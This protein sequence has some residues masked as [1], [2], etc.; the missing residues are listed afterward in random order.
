M[1]PIRVLVVDDSALMRRLI[2]D[3]LQ[4]DSDIE[5]VAAA[6]NGQEA[7]DLLKK[8]DVDV[9]TLDIEMPVMDGLL[10]L[11]KIQM[12]HRL[13]V[14]MLSS[15][16]TAGADHTI[17]ALELGAF[18][19]IAK[20]SGSI[21]LDIE[22][23]ASELIAKVKAAKNR[24]PLMR[25]SPPTGYDR[26]AGI[27]SQKSAQSAKSVPFV[28]G[29]LKKL[30]AI[31]TSTGGPR[32]LQ[33]VLTQLPA[34]LPAAVVVVQHMPPGFTK[35]LAKRLDQI[36]AIRVDEA[37]NGQVLEMGHVYI[38]PGDY[39][40]EIKQT[41]GRCEVQ[42][43]QSPPVGGH[44]PAVDNLFFSVAKLHG[45]SL[46]AVILTGMGSDGSKGLRSIKQV[47]GKTISEAKETCIVYGMPKAAF[48]TG[49]VDAVVPL[50]NVAQQILNFLSS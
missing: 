7:L 41:G 33:T 24:K 49:C 35:S 31:G 30:V 50:E 18:D 17:R 28:D 13:P 22:K 32:A 11:P 46:Q 48:E 12:E 36:C 44:R 42:L 6:R 14:I 2:T 19:F 8:H 43:D 37:T 34:D 23:V 10:T 21:S 15:L 39:H 26:F 47:G 3:M 29:K 4:A 1:T 38:A 40:M 9:V 20:P 25:P 45:I 5:V 27:S 16:T